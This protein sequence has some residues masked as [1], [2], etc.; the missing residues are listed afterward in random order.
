MDTVK[1]KDI[2]DLRLAIENLMIGA[3]ACLADDN[4]DVDV[5]ASHLA[6]AIIRLIE[7]NEVS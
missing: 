2:D 3:V 1:I 6:D 5:V 4:T 7:Y